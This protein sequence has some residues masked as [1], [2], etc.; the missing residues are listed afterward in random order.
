MWLILDWHRKPQLL[1]G[2]TVC[3]EKNKHFVLAAQGQHVSS[4]EETYMGAVS[5]VGSEFSQ[6]SAPAA[7]ILTG[8][9]HRPKHIEQGVIW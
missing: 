9:I 8:F 7:Q 2:Q 5:P 4:P 1:S 6:N 3:G